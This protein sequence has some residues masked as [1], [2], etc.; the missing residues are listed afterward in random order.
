MYSRCPIFCFSAFNSGGVDMI[1]LKYDNFKDV[2]NTLWNYSLDLKKVEIIRIPDN[3]F[4][5][6][7]YKE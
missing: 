2:V 7:I 5:L 1:I 6:I 3:E 4:I